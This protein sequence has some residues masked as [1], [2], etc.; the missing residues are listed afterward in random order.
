MEVVVM[1]VL[2]EVALVAVVKVQWNS[3]GGDYGGG[4]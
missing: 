1:V 3:G 2:I 4:W